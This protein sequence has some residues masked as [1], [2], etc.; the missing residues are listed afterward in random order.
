VDELLADLGARGIDA[1][2]LARL[3][4]RREGDLFRAL[5]TVAARTSRLGFDNLSGAIRRGWRRSSSA[6]ARGAS[7]RT[8][9]TRCSATLR[10]GRAWCSRRAART[11]RAGARPERAARSR[12]AV[13]AEP[14]RA[15]AAARAARAALPLAE[16]MARGARQRRGGLG[17]RLRQGP[18]SARGRSRVPAGAPTSGRRSAGSPALT[19]EMLEEGT[20]ALSGSASGRRARRPGRAALDGAGDEELVLRLSVLDECRPR[21]LELLGESCC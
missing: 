12:A 4:R 7:R 9:A 13:P 2:R 18:L 19:A 3:Q 8:C 16:R 10:G 11:R 17:T 15:H 21:A 20:R 1:A 14:E 5:E 6:G